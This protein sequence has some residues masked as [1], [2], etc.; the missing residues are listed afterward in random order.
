MD[1]F[2]HNVQMLLFVP[3]DWTCWPFV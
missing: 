3:S 2:A 1:I